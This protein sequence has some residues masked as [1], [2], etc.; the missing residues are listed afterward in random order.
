MTYPDRYY[1]M[2]D[3]HVRTYSRLSVLKLK[4]RCHQISIC[5]FGRLLTTTAVFN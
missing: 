5:N 4:F 1:V 2:Q 3:S